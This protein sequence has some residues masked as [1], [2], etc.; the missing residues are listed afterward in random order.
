MNTKRFRS[1]V[2]LGL[3]YLFVLCI[4][5]EAQTFVSGKGQDT[6]ACP[7][8]T[9]CLTLSYSL[10]Q[11]PLGGRVYVLDALE[12]D[13]RFAPLAI[14][15][16]VSII[17]AGARAGVRGNIYVTPEVGGQV[18]LKGL[19]IRA[20]GGTGLA[21]QGE[22]LTVVVDDCTI[23]DGADGI[24]F[25][26]TGAANSN[27]NVRNSII[28]RNSTAGLYIQPLST[29]KAL[30]VIENVNVNNNGQ[31]VLAYDNSTVTLRNSVSSENVFSGVRSEAVAGGQVSV[32]VEHSQMSHNGGSGVI[33][34]GA[35]AVVRITDVTITNNLVGVNYSSGGVVYSYGNN[36]IAA[37]ASTLAPTVTPLG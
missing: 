2:L 27:L 35:T 28:A 26:P 15:Q 11:T 10:S 13:R 17:G 24:T 31:G 19:D 36:A 14:S 37:N 20:G 29:G 22:R 3:L 33:A 21:I 18:L 9:P 1:T 5:A 32:F 4:H 8:A 6:G 30:V 23:T 7:R 34:V 12:E 16:S 25:S